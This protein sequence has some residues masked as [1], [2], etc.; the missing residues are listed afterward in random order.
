MFGRYSNEIDWSF[1]DSPNSINAKSCYFTD[2]L[3]IELS[4]ILPEKRFAVHLNDHL[5][6]NEDLYG[7]LLNSD[8]APYSPEIPLY[9]NYAEIGSIGKEKI[10]RLIIKTF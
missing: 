7:I 1:L 3:S 9:L 8:S 2:V 4:Y 10:V 5:W 6:I